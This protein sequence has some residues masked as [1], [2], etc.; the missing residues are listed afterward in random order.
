MSDVRAI[1]PPSSSGPFEFAI[2]AGMS[3]DLPVPYAQIMDPYQT[4]V[5]F[6]PWLAAHHSVDLW[7]DDW[8]EATKREMIAQCA[9][10]STIYPGEQLAELKGT[11][12]GLK[13]YL[14]FV[15]AEV[16]DRVAYPA[17]FVIGQ[18]ALGITPLNHPPFKARY[19]IKVTLEKPVNAFIIGRSAIGLAA[20]RPPSLEPIERAKAAARAAKA[21]HCEYTASFTHR[22]RIRFGDRIKFGDNA[23]F[24]SFRPRSTLR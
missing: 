1:M 4:P 6:L 14:W 5:R 2:A 8:S 19:L 20:L 23:K 3:D 11:F 17:R 22:R 18:S 10:V 12:E 13:R 15:G 7:Y 24:G 9:G 16:L 21:E